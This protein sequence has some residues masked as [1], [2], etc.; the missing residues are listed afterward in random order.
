MV[1]GNWYNQDGL[2]LQYGTQKAVPEVAGDYHVYGE[3]REI[4]HLVPL[5]PM[6]FTASNPQV[7]G[8]PTAAFSATGT[9]QAA[10][11]LSLTT[12]FPLAAV[13][14][15]T[16]A[17]SSLYTFVQ[18][19]IFIEQVEVETMSTVA[20]SG[21]VTLSAGLVTTSPQTNA[22]AQFAQISDATFSATGN[23]FLN[24]FPM[25]SSGT[26]SSAATVGSK[27]IYV[28]GGT[29]TEGWTFNGSTGGAA[30]TTGCGK[31]VGNFSPVPSNSI[32]PLPQSAWI[33]VIQST[34]GV[35]SGLL[36]L[37][38]KYVMFGSIAN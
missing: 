18:P 23:Q 35:T 32:T 14:P 29:T 13:A 1:A 34:T 19:Q 31:W 36:K 28:G 10:G 25:L 6:Q 5:V 11:I 30:T 7:P 21:T 38:I 17:S 9:A 27:T 37:R 3:V 15:I 26:A 24:A 2:Y 16:A 8:A 12:L 20:G 22:S 4:E 33:S